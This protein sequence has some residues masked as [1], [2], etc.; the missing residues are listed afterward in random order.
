MLALFQAIKIMWQEINDYFCYFVLA[1]LYFVL[2]FRLAQKSPNVG[3]TPFL[4]HMRKMTEFFKTFKNQSKKFEQ[5]SSCESVVDRIKLVHQALASKE[6]FRNV[7]GL[8]IN[9]GPKPD[10]KDRSKKLRDIGNKLYQ[11]K[12]FKEAIKSYTESMYEV[13]IDAEGKSKEIALALGNR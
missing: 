12:K 4:Q 8:F 3:V 10:N 11:T 2:L 7:T 9:K 6:E 5:F 13:T 1:T